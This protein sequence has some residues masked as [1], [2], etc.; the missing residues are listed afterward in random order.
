MG[1]EL[2]IA[3]DSKKSAGG[4]ETILVVE[5]EEALKVVSR[6]ILELRGLRYLKPA[7][8]HRPLKSVKTTLEPFIRPEKPI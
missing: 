8:V 1:K 5:D 4:I 7:M 2:E 6:R 3:A